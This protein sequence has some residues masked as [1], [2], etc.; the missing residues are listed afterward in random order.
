[1]RKALF[2]N[3][4]KLGQLE[5]T[6]FAGSTLQLRSLILNCMMIWGLILIVIVN[7]SLPKTLHP[8]QILDSGEDD[9]Q[10]QP[11]V[12]GDW[13][14]FLKTSCFLR[15]TLWMIVLCQRIGSPNLC[16]NPP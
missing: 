5:D 1:M 4:M 8:P 3:G 16:L 9:E 13:A 7:F 6:N 10:K 11:V 2:P 12:Y 15:R 14:M